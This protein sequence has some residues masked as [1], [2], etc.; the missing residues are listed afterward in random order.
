M[1]KSALRVPLGK[2]KVLHLLFFHPKL[3]YRMKHLHVVS[4]PCVQENKLVTCGSFFLTSD[5]R[6]SR[7]KEINAHVILRW[8]LWTQ[9]WETLL[10]GDYTQPFWWQTLIQAFYNVTK[11]TFEMLASTVIQTHLHLKE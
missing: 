8:C 11:P 7:W 9:S 3:D 2:L 1:R 6:A 10:W 5:L 4:F